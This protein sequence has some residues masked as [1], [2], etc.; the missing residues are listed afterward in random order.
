MTPG[1]R[2]ASEAEHRAGH[3]TTE[4]RKRAGGPLSSGGR[5]LP[6]E[7]RHRSPQQAGGHGMRSFAAL[8][9]SLAGL[10]AACGGGAAPAPGLTTAPGANVLPLTVNGSTCGGPSA[11]YPNKPCVSVQVC[12]PGTTTCVTVNNLLLDTGSYGL[13]LF[14]EALPFSL[15]PAP[16]RRGRAG[17]VRGLPR[18]QLALGTGG[19]RRRDPGRRAGRHRAHPDHRLHLRHRSGHLPEAGDLRAPPA[20]TASSAWGPSPRTAAPAAPHPTPPTACTSPAP[21]A[22][23]PAPP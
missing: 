20:T 2:E 23:A 19:E 7:C 5:R 17:R 16:L 11:S 8:A 22:P 15:A 6:R 18:R 14:K 3:P 13:R 9:A 1:R 21:A 4:Q 10:L 12:V